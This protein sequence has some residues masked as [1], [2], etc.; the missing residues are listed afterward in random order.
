MNVSSPA[1]LDTLSASFGF[2]DKEG[3]AGK[4]WLI[5]SFDLAAHVINIFA[6]E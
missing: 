4:F 1:V 5:E 6:E 2:R 3:R